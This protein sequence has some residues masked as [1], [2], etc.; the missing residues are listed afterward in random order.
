M[1]IAA[2]TPLK[3]N[4]MTASWGGLGILWNKP[5]AYI[6]IRPTRY[7]YE[8]LNQTN[9]F[10]INIFSETYRDVLK[11]CGAKSGRNFDKMTESKLTPMEKHNTIFF[12]ESRL[13]LLCKKI[14]FQ[15][16][17]PANFLDPEIGKNYSANDYHRMFIGEI[18]ECGEINQETKKK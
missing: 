6:F 3:Y 4:M 7:T 2:G 8:F 16:L 15:D 1:L 12:A 14:Y 13:V 10:S 17:D 18:V 5:V 11:I 9:V